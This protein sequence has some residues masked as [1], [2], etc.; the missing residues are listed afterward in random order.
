[1]AERMEIGGEL[2]EVSPEAWKAFDDW[3][4]DKSYRKA[5]VVAE[6]ESAVRKKISDEI[7]EL[8]SRL[9]SDEDDSEYSTREVRDALDWAMGIAEGDWDDP[10]SD[11]E[12]D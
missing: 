3:Y 9:R 1:M 12:D 7:C 10:D 2:W 8:Q 5:G 4:G 11:E 6:I